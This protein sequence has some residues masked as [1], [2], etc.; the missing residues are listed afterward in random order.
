[1][2]SPPPSDLDRL[3]IERATRRLH[4]LCRKG[5]FQE[6]LRV[7]EDA[8]GEVPFAAAW[9]AQWEAVAL[10]GL[11]RERDAVGVLNAAVEAGHAWQPNLLLADGGLATLRSR[12]DFQALLRRSETSLRTQ[13][14]ELRADVAIV[15]APRQSSAPPLLLLLG[16]GAQAPAEFAAPWLPPDADA[17]EAV[18]TPTQ[19]RTTDVPFRYFDDVERSRQDLAAA[20]R[21]LDGNPFD[22]ERVVLGGFSRGGYVALALSLDQHPVRAA[23]FVSS[24]PGFDDPAFLRGRHPAPGGRPLGWIVTGED[25]PLRS[26]GREAHTAL[27]EAGFEVELREAPGVGHS[28]PPLLAEVVGDCLRRIGR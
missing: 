18:A 3:S 8:R 27:V 21:G 16:G 6:M 17:L 4:E 24:N 23:A 5:A 14:A 11:G 25:D 20:L 28:P 7:T 26:R 22:G 9:N 19:L 2:T 12:E 15:K 13:E 10:C 1:M